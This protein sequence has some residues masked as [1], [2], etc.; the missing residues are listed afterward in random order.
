[1]RAQGPLCPAPQAPH[2]APVAA[3]STSVWASL[4]LLCWN[5]SSKGAGSFVGSPGAPKSRWCVLG[6]N[7]EGGM[8]SEENSPYTLLRLTRPVLCV[9]SSW[10]RRPVGPFLG[11]R[12]WTVAGLQHAIRVRS[13]FSLRYLMI[14]AE[15]VIKISR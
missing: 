14:H 5:A 8:S 6:L 4:H 15:N 2:A 12:S 3:R 1:M 10:N 9:G 7:P 13:A 11:S